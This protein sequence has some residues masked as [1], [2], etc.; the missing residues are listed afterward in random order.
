VPSTLLWLE[1]GGI[2]H[3]LTGTFIVLAAIV[4]ALSMM[5]IRLGSLVQETTGTTDGSAG[6]GAVPADD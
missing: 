4:R 3:I 5:P 1:L 6:E 2:A